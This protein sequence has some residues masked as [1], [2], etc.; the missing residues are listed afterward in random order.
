MKHRHASIAV[1]LFVGFVLCV[2]CGGEGSK[3]PEPVTTTFK[4]A[5]MTCESCEQAITHTLGQLQGVS[6]V[7]AHHD[8]G[9]A[10]VTYD[11]AKVSHETIS[12]TIEGLGY[13]VVSP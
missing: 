7:E 1:C 4:V 12:E 10:T 9:E 6:A 2:S 11:V 8:P 3:P 13:T 5:G